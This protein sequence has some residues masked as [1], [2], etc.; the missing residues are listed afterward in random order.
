LRA[1]REDD[2]PEVLETLGL[3]E[4]AEELD[5]EPRKGCVMS[6]DSLRRR[7][8]SLQSG[9]CKACFVRS[10]KIH[11]TYPEPLLPDDE[12]RPL[13]PPEYCPECGAEVEVA[14]IK[15]VYDR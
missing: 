4:F 1:I 12:D 9:G 7:L 2:V 11:V 14:V 8:D 10:S 6:N 3:G 5:A 15:V 13:P